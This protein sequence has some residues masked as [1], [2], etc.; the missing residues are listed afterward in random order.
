MSESS[1]AAA[2]KPVSSA[3]V[4]LASPRLTEARERW[5]PTTRATRR[6]SR[7]WQ[8]GYELSSSRESLGPGSHVLL[9]HKSATLFLPSLSCALAIGVIMKS[10]ASP[11][12]SSRGV[13][14][15]QRSPKHRYPVA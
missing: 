13:Q 2:L 6:T 7:S 1:D 9:T 3:A 15:E 8:M 12:L 10:S 14:L 5:R 11:T 4:M